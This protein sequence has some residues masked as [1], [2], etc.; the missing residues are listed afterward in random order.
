[1]TN[2]FIITYI[3]YSTSVVW[4]IFAI[5][6]NGHIAA[7][8]VYFYKFNSKKSAQFSFPTNHRDLENE[9]LQICFVYFMEQSEKR[10]FG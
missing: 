5:F 9:Y 10:K 6:E 4:P 7:G 3:T 8:Q 2:F 1:M